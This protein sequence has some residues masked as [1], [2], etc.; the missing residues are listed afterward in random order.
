MH[1]TLPGPNAGV[2]AKPH[3]GKA[4]DCDADPNHGVGVAPLLQEDVK[5]RASLRTEQ[6]PYERAPGH[7]TSNNK[8]IC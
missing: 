3:T 6:G 7:S 5:Q 2:D 4:E 1:P 8:A